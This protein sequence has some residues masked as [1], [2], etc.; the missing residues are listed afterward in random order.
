MLCVLTCQCCGPIDCL[1][2]RFRRKRPA[3]SQEPRH[4]TIKE[5]SHLKHTQN[6]TIQHIAITW[7]FATLCL[8]CWIDRIDLFVLF[9]LGFTSTAVCC[10]EWSLYCIRSLCL[11]SVY[12]TDLCSLNWLVP[13]FNVD[14]WRFVRIMR[15]QTAAAVTD[16][17]GQ[18]MLITR[19]IILTKWQMLISSRLHF[20][21]VLP[22]LL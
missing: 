10:P 20:R 7:V 9:I 12:S 8:L 16:T 3:T 19:L 14:R 13:V 1:H 18:H 22:P 21:S 17:F 5:P 6:V 11:C 4:Q 2:G 15:A